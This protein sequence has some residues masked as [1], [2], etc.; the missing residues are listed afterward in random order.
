LQKERTVKISYFFG[1]VRVGN[2]EKRNTTRV[3]KD[4]PVWKTRWEIKKEKKT[5]VHRLK[6]I[7]G[8]QRIERKALGMIHKEM[9]GRPVT[10]FAPKEKGFLIEHHFE[11]GW[12]GPKGEEKGGAIP[13]SKREI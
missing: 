13:S 9:Q 5:T 1:A 4:Y 8:Y 12:P 11:K 2:W 3:G 6:E 10:I 7:V